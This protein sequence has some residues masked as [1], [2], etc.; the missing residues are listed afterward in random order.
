MSQIGN[1]EKTSK[2][3]YAIPAWMLSLGVVGVIGGASGCGFPPF[4]G[5]FGTGGARNASTS[6][7][8]S[9]EFS[10]PISDSYLVSLTVVDVTDSS[11]GFNDSGFA[12]APLFVAT[13][14]TTLTLVPNTGTTLP[15]QTA[16]SAGATE[17]FAAALAGSVVNASALTK[18]HHESK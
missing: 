8:P 12:S 13:P 11:P 18:S 17:V 1:A 7:Q 16:V 4:G 6:N 10:G 15:G 14:D 9:F 5:G 3:R 2:G